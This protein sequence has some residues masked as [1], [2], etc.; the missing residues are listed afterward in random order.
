MGRAGV[1]IKVACRKSR[2]V[3]KMGVVGIRQLLLLP[4]TVNVIRRYT[5]L[6]GSFTDA[7]LKSVCLPE[8][9]TCRRQMS[10]FSAAPQL[11]SPSGTA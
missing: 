6:G 3:D 9:P 5:G 11:L 10:P 8:S 2:V 7:L 4:C 1:T